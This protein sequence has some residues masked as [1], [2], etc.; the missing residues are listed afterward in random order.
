MTSYFKENKKIIRESFRDE[1]PVMPTKNKW[2]MLDDPEVLQRFFE[3]KNTTSLL[4]FLED[5]V[6]L[7]DTMNHHGR[8]LIDHMSV[9][10]QINT[11]TLERVTDLDIEWAQKVDEIYRDTKQSK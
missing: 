4:Y 2:S 8:V 3:F 11:K 9:L 1:L 7:Q 5:L 10:V 6:Q